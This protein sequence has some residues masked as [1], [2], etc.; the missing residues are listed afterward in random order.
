MYVLVNFILSD[1]FTQIL[2]ILWG[3]KIN[4]FSNIV[5]FIITTSVIE[6]SSKI[7]RLYFN[8]MFK[9]ILQQVFMIIHSV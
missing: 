2:I 3:N 5:Y 6:W 7:C 9:N 8:N 4:I 1:I